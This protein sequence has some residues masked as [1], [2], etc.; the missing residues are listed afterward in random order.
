[1]DLS[2]LVR[3][4]PDD[5]SQAMATSPRLRNRNRTQFSL[6]L[7][8]STGQ[9]LTLQLGYFS[10][11]ARFSL[12]PHIPYEQSDITP[13]AKK[14]AVTAILYAWYGQE[15]ATLP[16]TSNEALRTG[17]Y[18]TRKKEVHHQS[19]VGISMLVIFVVIFGVG[20][21]VLTRN[22]SNASC[23][24]MREQGV[25]ATAT[26]NSIQLDNASNPSDHMWTN[27]IKNAN[28]IV[29]HVTFTARNGTT[30]T[31]PIDVDY[32]NHA[33]LT[34][35]YEAA[36]TGTVQVRYL[37][38]KPVA[39]RLQSAFVSDAPIELCEDR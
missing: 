5:L 31:E 27:N 28:G 2:K 10:T 8:D 33:Y 4:A 15:V 17:A 34:K 9:S 14:E 11:D 30:Y 1:M 16:N 22:P 13:E 38:S 32:S 24:T 25:V 36:E 23:A 18:T 7:K 29:I 6:I 12:L 21:F 3:I 39:V 37:P 19:V 26:V 20:W 35:A